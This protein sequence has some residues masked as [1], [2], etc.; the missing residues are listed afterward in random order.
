MHWKVGQTIYFLNPCEKRNILLL[1]LATFNTSLSF[2]P[3]TTFDLEYLTNAATTGPDK[4][5]CNYSHI[6]LQEIKNIQK[7]LLLEFVQGYIG[8]MS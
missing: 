1:L 4:F 8:H 5:F 7:V 3:C 6:C 2:D